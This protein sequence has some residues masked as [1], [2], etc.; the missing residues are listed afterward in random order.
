MVIPRSSLQTLSRCCCLDQWSKPRNHQLPAKSILN[1]KNTKFNQKPANTPNSCSEI[2][3]T[4]FKKS[5]EIWPVF[6]GG[7]FWWIFGEPQHNQNPPTKNG[8]RPQRLP[9]VARSKA[10]PT[11][12]SCHLDLSSL[13]NV[14]T[15]P[16]RK[17]PTTVSDR[18]ESAGF[19]QGSQ[20]IF[21]KSPFCSKNESKKGEVN[22]NLYFDQPL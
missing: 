11:H 14:P 5:S 16:K 3:H 4:S 9:L 2:F 1:N 8:K 19:F 13:I 7:R 6:L 20:V 22:E 17:N 18:G 10:R 15:S 12:R 21:L